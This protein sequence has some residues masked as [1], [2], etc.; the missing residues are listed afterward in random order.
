MCKLHS[1]YKIIHCIHCVI[2]HRG[3]QIIIHCTVKCQF[4]AFNLEKNYTGQKK[5]TQTTPVVSVTNM[6]YA[7][8]CLDIYQHLPGRNAALPL[9]SNK[10]CPQAESLKKIIH[11]VFF[12]DLSPIQEEIGELLPRRIPSS[13]LCSAKY[14][15]GKPRT[16]E[17]E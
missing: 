7:N 10:G 9:Q 5:I 11:Y 1:V 8:T 4:F 15:T 12:V 2:L 13:F 6:R 17:E 3:S 14:C 16:L